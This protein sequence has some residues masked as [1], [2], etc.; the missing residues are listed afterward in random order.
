LSLI[1]FDFHLK[2]CSV[3]RLS[4]EVGWKYK[5]VIETLELKRKAK[6][7]IRF[8]RKKKDDKLRAEA[9]KSLE[10]KLKPLRD[11]ITSY[12]YDV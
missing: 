3:G 7:A 1:N 9:K 11:I 10:K 6:A 4:H 5:T 8:S 2:Y 12:G